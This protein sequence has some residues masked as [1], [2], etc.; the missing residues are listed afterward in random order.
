M[1]AQIRFGQNDSFP[2]WRRHSFFRVHQS[3]GISDQWIFF[4]EYFLGCANLSEYWISEWQW[5]NLIS[6]VSSTQWNQ[7]IHVTFMTFVTFIY[8]T[9]VTFIFVNDGAK[10]WLL[11]QKANWTIER[12]GSKKTKQLLNIMNCYCVWYFGWQIWDVL[13][14]CPLME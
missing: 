13:K 4:S 10:N 7:N 8:V 11:Y 12:S 5:K 9:F 2:R 1:P 3:L 6:R 14:G